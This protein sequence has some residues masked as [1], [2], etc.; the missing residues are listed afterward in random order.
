VSRGAGVEQAQIRELHQ[1]HI[2]AAMACVGRR[3]PA[4]IHRL[5]LCSG[6]HTLRELYVGWHEQAVQDLEAIMKKEIFQDNRARW[7]VLEW[8]GSTRTKVFWAVA[9]AIV[10]LG[11]AYLAR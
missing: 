6:R 8:M 2:V 4:H 1:D 11:I 10:V 3:H 7:E 5:H 9:A